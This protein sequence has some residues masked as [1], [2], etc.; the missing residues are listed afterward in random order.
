M[1]KR[2][3]VCLGIMVCGGTC[4]A[5]GAGALPPD[6]IRA[7]ERI[8]LGMTPSEVEAVIGLSPGY[9]D[10]G[11]PMPPFMSPCGKCVRETGLP[12]TALPHAA[13]MVR[14]RAS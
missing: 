1:K 14:L 5:L 6:T 10:G 2:W 11:I 7:Y 13:G 9:H 12:S 3:A 4:W 8:R